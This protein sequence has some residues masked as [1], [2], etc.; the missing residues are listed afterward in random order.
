MSYAPHIAFWAER[1]RALSAELVGGNQE[2]LSGQECARIAS[3]A[4]GLL[5][6]AHG[7]VTMRIDSAY[8]AIELLDRL[9]RENT[10][11]TV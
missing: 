4:L 5:P 6:A 11:F 7:P 10:R 9:R 8:Y 1:G 2:R 3:R